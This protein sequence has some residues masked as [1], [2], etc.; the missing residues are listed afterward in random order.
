MIFVIEKT[1]KKKRFVGKGFELITYDDEYLIFKSVKAV[2]DKYSLDYNS[3]ARRL[4]LQD[5]IEIGNLKI[6]RKSFS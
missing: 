2:C 1:G 3:T 6:E 4:R 5:R